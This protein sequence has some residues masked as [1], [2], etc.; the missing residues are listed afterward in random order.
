MSTYDALDEAIA[1]NIR[2][3]YWAVLCIQ[4]WTSLSARTTSGLECEFGPLGEGQPC[5][6]LAVFA[7][8]EEAEAWAAG[9]QVIELRSGEDAQ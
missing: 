2:G 6:F 3:S 5:G 8:R 7:S 9:S 1:D 4:P